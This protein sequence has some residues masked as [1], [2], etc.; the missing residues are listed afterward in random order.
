MGNFLPRDPNWKVMLHYLPLEVVIHY[1][2][3]FTIQL[4][5][6]LGKTR[7]D[8]ITELTEFNSSP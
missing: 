4:M 1:F 8:C 5:R 6:R 7:T 2:P 3:I